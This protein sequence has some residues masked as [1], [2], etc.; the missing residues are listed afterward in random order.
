MFGVPAHYQQMASSLLLKNK[1]LSFIR[2]Y[3][4]G[5]DAITVVPSRA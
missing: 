4:A 1:D 2:N 3:A 5:G